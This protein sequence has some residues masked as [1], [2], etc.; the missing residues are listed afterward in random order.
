MLVYGGHEK[1]HPPLN[2]LCGI[3]LNA[4]IGTATQEPSAATTSHTFNLSLNSLCGISLNATSVGDGRSITLLTKIA[5]SQFPLWDFFECNPAKD[6]R[7]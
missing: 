5:N 6:Y 1:I 2:S 4:T 7:G 3:S